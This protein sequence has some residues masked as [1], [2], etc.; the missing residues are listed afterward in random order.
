MALI[1]CYGHSFVDAKHAHS[2][3]NKIEFVISHGFRILLKDMSENT[4]RLGS[5]RNWKLA[6]RQS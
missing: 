6:I 4:N 1:E 5:A 2:L 3:L